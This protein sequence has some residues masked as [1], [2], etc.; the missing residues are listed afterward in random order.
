M[1]TSQ[2]LHFHFGRKAMDNSLY[3]VI[4]A[5]H[6][7]GAA[8]SLREALSNAHLREDT[9]LSRFDW[10]VDQD[11]LQEM[12]DSWK[13]YGEEEWREGPDE[14]P[15]E[16]LIFWLDHE[17]WSSFR[18]CDISG[19]ISAVPK[20]LEMTSDQASKK[21]GEIQIRALFDNGVLKP[22]K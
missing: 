14:R 20:N 18:V 21:L 9:R 15:T 12:W 4:A 3:V 5:N 19:G 13:E 7:W 22:L 8:E 16:C 2:K 17:V 10:V 11:E 1:A 6:C